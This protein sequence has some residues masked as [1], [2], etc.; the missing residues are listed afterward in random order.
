MNRPD[1]TVAVSRLALGVALAAGGAAAGCSTSEELAA[2]ETGDRPSIEIDD[3]WGRPTPPGTETGAFYFSIVSHGS[4]PDRLMAAT[5]DRCSAIEL[6]TTS[7]SEGVMAMRP[8]DGEAL[9]IEAGGR[10]VLEPAGLHAMC[11][12]LSS[13]LVEGERIDLELELLVAGSVSVTVA[14]NQR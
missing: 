12:G 2:T 5:S 10:L 3:P 6:H 13:P 1:P 9:T 8:A 14:V 11:L 7:F 4:D